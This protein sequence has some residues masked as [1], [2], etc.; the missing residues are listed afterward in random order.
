MPKW[1]RGAKGAKHFAPSFAP[2]HP[3]SFPFAPLFQFAPPLHSLHPLPLIKDTQPFCTNPGHLGGTLG[4]SR[5][6]SRV[7]HLGWQVHLRSQMSAEINMLKRTPNN[8][9]LIQLSKILNPFTPTQDTLG[10]TLGTSRNYSRM[11]HLGWQV[12]LWS[13]MIVEINMLKR[14][15]NTQNLFSYQRYS[16]LSH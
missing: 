12:H 7:V 4:T 5:N 16:T 2:L 14:T 13:Q 15:P 9:K 10:F 6:Y 1:F 3:P 11:V 8:T